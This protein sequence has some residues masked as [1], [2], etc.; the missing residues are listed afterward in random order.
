LQSNLTKKRR[1]CGALFFAKS[2]EKSRVW[3]NPGTVLGKENILAELCDELDSAIWLV[4]NSEDKLKEKFPG[5][6]YL[7]YKKLG[8]Q[9][10]VDEAWKVQL[11]KFSRHPTEK[12]SVT[13]MLEN[14]HALLNYHLAIEDLLKCICTRECDCQ[15]PSGEGVKHVSNECPEHNDNQKPNPEC[16]SKKHWF[17]FNS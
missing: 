1:S 8:T 2:V 14:A 6:E 17:Q 4:S 5:H 10:E 15:N 16:S 9:R 11:R 12:G 7:A 3:R 13:G